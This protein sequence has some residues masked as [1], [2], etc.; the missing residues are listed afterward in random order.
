MPTPYL[1]DAKAVGNELTK[2]KN[3]DQNLLLLVLSGSLSVILASPTE[4]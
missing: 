1:T 3:Q 4:V 2:D